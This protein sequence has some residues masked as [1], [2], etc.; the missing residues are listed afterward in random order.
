MSAISKYLR[1]QIDGFGREYVS[2]YC[3]GCKE[4][5][6]VTV[7]QPEGVKG[8][9][10]AWNRDVLRPTFSPS[11]LVRRGGAIDP[12]FV[13]EEGDP[14]NVCHTFITDGQVQFLGDCDH[15]FAGTTQPLL[16]FRLFGDQVSDGDEPV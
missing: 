15:E 10:W 16:P 11:V 2:Y 1:R 8:P 7:F 14:P 12:T 9:V 6:S 3:Q 5:H 4:A 13:K